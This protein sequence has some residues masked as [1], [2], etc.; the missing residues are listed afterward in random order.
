MNH[1][2]IAEQ[3]QIKSGKKR[4]PIVAGLMS[5][6]FPGLGQAYNGQFKKAILYFVLSIALYLFMRFTRLPVTF[7]GFL[8]MMGIIV[9]YRGL[10]FFDAYMS[11]VKQREFNRTN[12]YALY[13]CVFAGVLAAYYILVD[14]KMLTRFAA[15][16]I[17]MPSMHPA[18][19]IGDKVMADL[20][21]YEKK[22]IY[23]GDI[24][25]FEGPDGSDWTFRIVGIPHDTIAIANNV[26]VINGD[27]S[28]T[29]VA[30]DT[31]LL[32][33]IPVRKYGERFPDGH[34]HHIIFIEA[35]YNFPVRNV[36]AV[37][38]PENHYYLLGDYR[39]NSHDSRMFG[40]IHRDQIKGK[41]MYTYWGKTLD[42][43][44]VDLTVDYLQ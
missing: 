17:P 13:F 23:R 2:E 29:I 1:P 8:F 7:E 36:S 19:Q 28:K 34:K 18:M 41:I 14:F 42:R 30:S 27:T 21:A 32:D 16:K 44:G 10:A 31:F 26:V 11:A 43:S 12:K 33:K 6:I 40:F 15:F 38:V 5:I 22:E 35:T 20:R 4:I 24:V 25:L 37:V 39:D 9:L 3:I